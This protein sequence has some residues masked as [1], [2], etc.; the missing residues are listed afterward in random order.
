[1]LSVLKELEIQQETSGT[2]TG[3]DLSYLFIYFCSAQKGSSGP[4][5][6]TKCQYCLS[7]LGLPNKIP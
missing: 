4:M 7:Y 6:M 5:A 2:E 3:E 1:M